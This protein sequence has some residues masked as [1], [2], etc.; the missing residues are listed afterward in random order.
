[1][2]MT[3][4]IQLRRVYS[5]GS[6]GPPSPIVGDIRRMDYTLLQVIILM[7]G[8]KVND[9]KMNG[10]KR[11]PAS[12]HRQSRSDTLKERFLKK[13][14]LNLS[15]SREARAN[16]AHLLAKELA[17][18]NHVTIQV[19]NQKKDIYYDSGQVRIADVND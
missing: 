3:C 2:R 9:S 16:A 4:T 8:S 17:D 14:T 13:V 10:S 6:G 19:G 1:M 15:A 7:N 11:Q 5:V 18:G 12:N